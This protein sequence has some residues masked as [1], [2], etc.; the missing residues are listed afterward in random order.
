MASVLEK[1]REQISSAKAEYKS[2]R[3]DLERQ[4]E[5][6]DREYGALFGEVAGMKPNG[7]ARRTP[8]RAYGGVKTAVLDA[9]RSAKGIKPAQIVEKT[10]LSSPQVH[11]S[12]TGLKKDKLVKVKG[13]LYTT[14]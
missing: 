4:I 6:L 1:L 13:R 8:S 10:G 5:T 7:R 11:N 2:R 12:L 3:R 14:A 9:I